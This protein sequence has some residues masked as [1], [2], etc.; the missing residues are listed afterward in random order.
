M[1]QLRRQYPDGGPPDVVS[2]H[3][4]IRRQFNDEVDTYNQGLSNVQALL[5]TYQRARR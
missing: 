2:Q 4:R 3:E 5:A 1:E